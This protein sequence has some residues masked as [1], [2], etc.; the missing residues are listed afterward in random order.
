[1][2]PATSIEDVSAW[3]DAWVD[4]VR[5]ARP[6]V[7]TI[8]SF[9]LLQVLAPQASGGEKAAIWST[10]AHRIHRRFSHWTASGPHE[11]ADGALAFWGGIPRGDTVIFRDDGEVFFTKRG[12][13]PGP[14]W[15]PDYAT[16]QP[17]D[18]YLAAHRDLPPHAS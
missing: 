14:T 6:D 1:M 3:L 10:L 17:L 13:R 8:A 2:S 5:P 18:A 16:M 7:L 15:Q 11:V 4:A 12:L 9:Q